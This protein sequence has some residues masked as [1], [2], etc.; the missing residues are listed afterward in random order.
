MTDDV[1]VTP[2]PTRLDLPVGTYAFQNVGFRI[3]RYAETD[4]EVAD[5]ADLPSG[6]KLLPKE[7]TQ[8][9]I[10]DVNVNAVYAWCPNGEGFLSENNG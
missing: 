6:N 5:I 7:W 1:R 9:K 2:V 3:I 8:F 10:I 4:G